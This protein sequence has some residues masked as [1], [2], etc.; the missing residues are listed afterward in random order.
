M[1]GIKLNEQA[2]KELVDKVGRCEL[3]EEMESTKDSWSNIPYPRYLKAVR[4]TLTSLG[5]DPEWVEHDFRHALDAKYLKN[6]K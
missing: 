2:T 6:N 5:F 4:V 1:N 3:F